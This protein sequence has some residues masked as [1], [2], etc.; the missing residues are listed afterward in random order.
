MTRDEGQCWLDALR[1]Y[2]YPVDLR[3]FGGRNQFG[4]N[5]FTQNLSPG[6]GYQT[7][8]FEDRFRRNAPTHLEA[9]FEV[10]FWKLFSMP[11]VRNRRTLALIERSRR[12]NA[13][14]FW[15]ACTDFVH[16]CSLDSFAILQQFFVAG[17]GLPVVAT[18]VAFA[19]PERFPMVDL[20]IVRSVRSYLSAYPQAQH[21]G[22]FARQH[23]RAITTHDWDFYCAWIGWC[24]SSAVIL[25]GVT[26]T[27]WRARDVEMAVF[28]NSR[29]AM[30]PLPPIA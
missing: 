10:V 24:R 19:A 27:H 15:D 29:N 1:Q 11:H 8:A 20:W 30:P 16:E 13:Q 17:S 21:R 22:L 4:Q 12:G 23:D 6:N 28:Q 9:W 7:A 18:F 5:W 14:D 2:N 3:A 25:E 26:D